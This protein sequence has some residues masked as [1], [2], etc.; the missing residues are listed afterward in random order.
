LSI[1][2]GW[3][4]EIRAQEEEGKGEKHTPVGNTRNAEYCDKLKRPENQKK[5]EGEKTT[6]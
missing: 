1:A 6:S 3:K 4:K 5:L 2:S